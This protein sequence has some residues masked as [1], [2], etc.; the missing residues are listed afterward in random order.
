MI[1]PASVYGC[2]I[3]NKVF[4][5]LFKGS[6]RIVMKQIKILFFCVVKDRN[7]LENFIGMADF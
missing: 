2:L 4:C 5:I 3:I 7:S 6:C 1:I